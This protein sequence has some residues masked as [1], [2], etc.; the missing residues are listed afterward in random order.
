MLEFFLSYQ[1]AS[2]KLLR[3]GT[4]VDASMTQVTE[5]MQKIAS[6]IKNPSRLSKA[7]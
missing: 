6:H 1:S 3:F 4:T 2:G 7:F 5:A